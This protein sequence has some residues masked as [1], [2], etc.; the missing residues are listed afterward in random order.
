MGEAERKVGT[1]EITGG[2]G[3]G[4]GLVSLVGFQEVLSLDGRG[5][6]RLP[7]ELAAA[8]HTELG[9]LGA[10]AHSYD[11]LSFYFV[12]GTARRIFLYPVPNVQLAI[13]GFESPPPGMDPKVVRRARDYFYY[14]MRFVEGDRQNRFGLPEGVRQHAGIS[15]DVQRV[16]LVAHNHWLSLGRTDLEE[17]RA[18][19][20]LETF[21]SAADDLLDPV[22]AVRPAIPT[23]PAGSTEGDEQP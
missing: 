4:N 3:R 7:D 13:D 23:P 15:D 17:Q 19:E 1:G 21:D 6:F 16:T 10:P 12:P 8:L 11:R 20:D 2:I 22:Y 9:R 18:L 14:R 5:R